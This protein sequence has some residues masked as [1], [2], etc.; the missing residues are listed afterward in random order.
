MSALNIILI[1]FIINFLGGFYRTCKPK[2]SSAWFAGVYWPLLIL[3]GLWIFYKPCII[4][5]L[6][7]LGA[8]VL[9]QMS[10]RFFKER[11]ISPADREKLEQIPDFQRWER[12]H[13]W[14]SDSDTTIVL[15]NMGGPLNQEE[16]EPFLKRLFMDPLIIRFPLSG[17][18]QPLFAYILVKLRLKEVKRRY[19]LIGGGSPL[20]ESSVQQVKALE[21]E[22]RKRGRNIDVALCF[23]YTEPF[24]KGVIKEVRDKDK[25]FILPLSLYP[26]YSEST[27][28][29]NLF[30]L[31][32]E[33]AAQGADVTF[34]NCLPYHL[35]DGYIQA[36][37]DRIHSAIGPQ[38]MMEDYYLLFSAHG[39][40]LYFLT[41][42]D[43]YSYSVAQSVARI[44]GVLNR[45][46]NWVISYQS[47]VGP[48]QWLKPS[49]EEVL[50]ALAKKGVKK[51]IVVPISFVNDHI[52]TLCEI[53]MEYRELAEKKLGFTDFR[54]TK[55]LECHHS[56][57]SALAD[58]AEA[59]LEAHGV[60]G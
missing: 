37:V 30:Y 55:A 31:K 40:P 27:A 42:G 38:A 18:L 54:M 9:G 19:A 39:T 20:F 8:L 58:C 60:N 48:M 23:N 5:I 1:S 49:T 33:A 32:K 41:E 28:A 17:L 50:A 36:F 7:S 46:H 53:D 10:G 47:L 21:N 44:L 15:M 29:S 6:L 24:P 57:I 25:R 56:F 43:T 4:F 14:V 35:Y 22:L 16:V 12:G 59:S 45:R 26:H 51:I 11:E 13:K 34:L 52:E 2:F 3:V